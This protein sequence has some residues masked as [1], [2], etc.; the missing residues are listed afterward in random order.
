MLPWISFVAGGLTGATARVA[1]HVARG[2]VGREIERRALQEAEAEAARMIR[3]VRGGVAFA[4]LWQNALLLVAIW[5][6]LQMVTVVPFCAAY[7]V[8]AGY[9]AW[10]VAQYR[11]PLCEA[12]RTCSLFAVVHSEVREAVSGS[13]SRLGRFERLVLVHLGP[14]LDALCERVA[15]RIYPAIRSACV[16]MAL[17]LGVS[18]LVFRVWLVPTLARGMLH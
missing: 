15:W 1:A 9:S 6:S 12:F 2:L 16:S 7:M 13:V 4:I 8:V 17:T 11:R 5:V 10:C 3:S 14:D 18:F